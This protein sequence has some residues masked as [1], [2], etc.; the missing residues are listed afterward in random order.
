MQ[1]MSSI[2]VQGKKEEGKESER[3]GKGEGE[4][5]SSPHFSEEETN[6]S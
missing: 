5:K 4:R 6:G 3:L 2:K 1:R